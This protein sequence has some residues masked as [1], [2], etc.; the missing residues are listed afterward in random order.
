MYM[1][2]S[3]GHNT[4]NKKKERSSFYNLEGQATDDPGKAVQRVGTQFVTVST[5]KNMSDKDEQTEDS[6]SLS[7]SPPQDVKDEGGHECCEDLLMHIINIDE[8][9]AKIANNM[10][11]VKQG[12]ADSKKLREKL[13]KVFDR[14][15]K[16]FASKLNKCIELNHKPKLWEKNNRD[17]GKPVFFLSGQDVSKPLMMPQ[18][19]VNPPTHTTL[20][21]TQERVHSQ[22][23]DNIT[24]SSQHQQHST[25]RQPS[26]LQYH[27][28]TEL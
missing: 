21:S 9:V 4:A 24:H 16:D 17:N 10:P 19:I 27:T 7:P 8:N 23:T 2:S 25:I 11:K 18:Q 6:L 20:P 12:D 22:R 15:P 28:A 13:P 1:S 3:H 26:T 14:L 5:F